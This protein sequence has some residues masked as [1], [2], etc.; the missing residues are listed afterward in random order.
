MLF[1]IGIFIIGFC[2]WDLLCRDLLEPFPSFGAL[3]PF[4]LSFGYIKSIEAFIFLLGLHKFSL[5]I[6]HCMKCT[7]EQGNRQSQYF[8]KSH[9]LKKSD[10]RKHCTDFVKIETYDCIPRIFCNLK[11]LN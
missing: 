4:D 9:F 5:R 1:S 10:K 2:I 8:Q 6:F 3:D 7:R 11:S